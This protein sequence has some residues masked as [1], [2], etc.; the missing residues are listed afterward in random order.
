MARKE[1]KSGPTFHNR[2]SS[3]LPISTDYIDGEGCI[4][5][6]HDTPRGKQEGN[7]VKFTNSPIATGFGCL[8]ISGTID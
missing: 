6:K 1:G 3:S 7:Q 2:K 4:M 5:S 8:S